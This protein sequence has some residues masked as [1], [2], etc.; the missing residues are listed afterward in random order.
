MSIRMFAAVIGLVYIGAGII[1]FM[2]W[3]TSSPP[4]NAPPLVVESYYGYLLGLFPINILHN[5][6]HIGIGAWGVLAAVRVS[7]AR[8][9]A[10]SIAAIYGLLA[11]LGVLPQAHTLFGYVPLFGHDVWLHAVTAGIAGYFGLSAPDE[12]VTVRRTTTATN[13]VKVYEEH[14][15]A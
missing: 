3:I 4:A 10:L 2:P 6:V 5:L 15:R 14:P 7:A 1:G 13:N 11:I 12:V 8:F 9:F